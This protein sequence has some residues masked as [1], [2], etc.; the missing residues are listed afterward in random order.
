[1]RSF[2]VSFL[3]LPIKGCIMVTYDAGRLKQ[4]ISE[5]VKA[6]TTPEI[7]TWLNDKTA[8]SDSNQAFNI[9]FVSI[10]RKTGKSVV[11]LTDAQ[12]RAIE[13]AGG[14]EALRGWTTDRL[15]RVWLL[16]NGDSSNEEQYIQR[17]ENL[18]LTAEVN[19]LVALYAALPVLSF[20]ERWIKRCAEGIRSNIGA[21][22]EAIMCDNPYPAAYLDEPAWNQ[23]IL[24]AFFT[25]KP[26]ERIIGIDE[27]ANA[28]LAQTLSDYAHER[29][30]AGRLVNP[31]IW[32]CTGRFINEE[33]LSDME[34]LFASPNELDREAAALACSDSQYAPALNLLNKNPNIQSVIASG[35][36]TWDVLAEKM[37]N[38][39]LQ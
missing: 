5:A 10:P 39:V 6:N 4:I 22:L 8:V 3:K 33:T 1:M 9:A 31:Q 21:A 20:P 26:V 28:L 7:Q 14:G 13:D 19:E 15:C 24:K 35:Q 29:W 2:T 30:A 11:V 12:T 16:A 34:R 25:D 17:I 32:R 27:R 18:F 38:Y 36:L 23:L 37:K